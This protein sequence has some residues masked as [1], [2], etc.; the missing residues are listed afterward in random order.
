MV[1][2]AFDLVQND[3]DSYTAAYL[4]PLVRGLEAYADANRA[5]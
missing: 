5:E 1:Y 2:K 4:R 3:L